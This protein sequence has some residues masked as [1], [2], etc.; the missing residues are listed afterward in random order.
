M[1][2]AG[3]PKLMTDELVTTLAA[4]AGGNYRVLTTM[5]YQLLGA[6]ARRK[7]ERLDQGLYLEVFDPDPTPPKKR[8]RT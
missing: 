1:S 8:R 6:A 5:A 3:A 7:R 2:E 4:H